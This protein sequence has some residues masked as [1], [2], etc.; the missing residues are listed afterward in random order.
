MPDPDQQPTPS[1]PLLSGE[2]GKD[3]GEDDNGD[4]SPQQSSKSLK[5]AVKGPKEG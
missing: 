5:V 1:D 3:G 2:D 4:Q